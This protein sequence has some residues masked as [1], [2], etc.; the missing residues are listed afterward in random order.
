MCDVYQL[1]S[2]ALYLLH[3]HPG[4]SLKT[5]Y[6]VRG[7]QGRGQGCNMVRGSWGIFRQIDFLSSKGGINEKKVQSNVTWIIT[8][9][10][11]HYK[12]IRNYGLWNLNKTWICHSFLRRE[13]AINWCDLSLFQLSLLGQEGGGNLKD[14]D[15]ILFT[16]FFMEVV[17]NHLTILNDIKQN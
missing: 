12:I 11:C 7:E 13:G 10:K 16:V 4:V 1:P 9:Q 6:Q 14:A 3:T 15:V 2:P 17:P 5:H 8:T